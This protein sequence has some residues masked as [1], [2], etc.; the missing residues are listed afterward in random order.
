MIKMAFCAFKIFRDNI[1]KMTPPPKIWNFPYVSSL[2]FLKASLREA[3]KK[4]TVIIMEFSII[5]GGGAQ[6]GPFP[7]FKMGGGGPAGS[8]SIF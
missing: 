1:W 5:G 8:F 3:F 6:G 7:F 2:F 4:K